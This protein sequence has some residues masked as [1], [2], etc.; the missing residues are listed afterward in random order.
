[1]SKIIELYEN[2]DEAVLHAYKNMQSTS[3]S[4]IPQLNAPEV[5]KDSLLETI[6]TFNYLWIV[7]KRHD[8]GIILGEVGGIIPTKKD[9][10]KRVIAFAERSVAKINYVALKLNSSP[11]ESILSEIEKTL[12]RK[13]INDDFLTIADGTSNFMHYDFT[14]RI[15]KDNILDILRPDPYLLLSK[16]GYTVVTDNHLDSEKYVFNLPKN[17]ALLEKILSYDNYDSKL[18]FI[19]QNRSMIVP[20]DFIAGFN[21]LYKDDALFLSPLISE[22]ESEKN[23]EYFKSKGISPKPSLIEEFGIAYGTD[24]I[25]LLKNF[26]D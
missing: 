23:K 5:L 20:S 26:L 4:F 14:A 21:V 8:K 7:Q 15:E 10:G 3:Q 9:T 17:F 1:M 2:S 25:S 22:S 24:R 12:E 13:I 6:L 18:N 19:R 16:Q 11:N